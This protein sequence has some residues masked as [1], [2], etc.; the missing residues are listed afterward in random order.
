MKKL[1]VLALAVFMCVG[2]FAGC[3]S[4]TPSPTTAP[5]TAAVATEAPASANPTTAPAAEKKTIT[6]WFYW[7][8]QLQQQTIAGVIDKY[9]T[10]QDKVTVKS[11]YIPFADFKK[12][13]SIGVVSDALPDI[14]ILDNP[15]HAAYAAMGIFAD[16]TDKLKDWPDLAQ[17][18]QGPINSCTLND[19]LYG[20]PFGSNDLMLYYNTDMM[21]KAGASVPK[22]WD[23]LQTVAKEL[24]TDKVTGFA[25]SCPQNEEGTFGFLTF[26]WSTGNSSFQ[27]NNEGGIKALTL[28]KN[29]IDS[30]AMSKEVINWTQGD[31]MHQ[32]ISGNVAMMINGPWQVPTIR[33]DAA[34]LKW[35]VAP[36]PQDKQQA[37]DLGGEN[38]AV[39]NNANVD[40]AVAF[41]KWIASPDVMKTYIDTYGYVASRKDVSATQFAGDDIMKAFVG[42]MQYASPRGPSPKWPDISNALSTAFNEVITG[43]DPAASAKKAQDA[44]DAILK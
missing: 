22:T 2:V 29:L 28:Y 9:N 15:D 21:S 18:Y 11:Q 19:K 23:D 41:L 5:T 13:L 3:N 14:V 36:I 43:G 12:Q 8:N 20:L 16:L 26:L 6:L 34:D 42:E 39:I 30:G 1:F 31:V 4:P 7:E 33:K 25:L 24:T 17:Y 10:S 32:F 40:D 38:F 37:S 27:I 44:I 35:A